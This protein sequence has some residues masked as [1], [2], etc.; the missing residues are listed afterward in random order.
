[1]NAL[2]DAMCVVSEHICQ[3]LKLKTE[4]ICNAEFTRSDLLTRHKR[5]CG[6]SLVF[7]I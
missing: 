6:D 2:I 3:A 7:S 4:Q 5:T 1:M